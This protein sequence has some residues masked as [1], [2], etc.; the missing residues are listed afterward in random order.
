[1]E[2][3]GAEAKERKREKTLLKSSSQPERI[4]GGQYGVDSD[5][6]SVGL[7]IVECALGSF[8]YSQAP[9]LGFWD[10]L[11]F[12]V[13]NPAPVLPPDQFSPEFCDF[14]AACLQKRPQDR[15]SATQLLVSCTLFVDSSTPLL[16]DCF[17]GGV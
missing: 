12:I 17:G 7:S 13:H 9:N 8:P 15:P 5:I 1:M 6:W 10:L 16:T 3:R 11:T 2:R 14:V 4:E